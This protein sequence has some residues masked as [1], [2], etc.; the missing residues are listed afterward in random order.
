MGKLTDMIQKALR[1]DVAGVVAAAVETKA[2]KAD[3]KASKVSL[4]TAEQERVAELAYIVKS[5]RGGALTDADTKELSAQF[6]AV[7]V[8]GD[9]PALLPD[10]FTGTLLRDI[11]NELNVAKLF[12]M[13]QVAGGV[14]HDLIALGGVTAYLTS[15]A[16]DGTDSAESYLTFVKTT[17]KVMAVVRKSYEAVND[18]LIDLA[19]EIRF[20]LVR[21]IAEA[22]EDAVINGDLSVTHMDNGVAAASAK[23]VCNGIR[24]HALGKATVDFGGAA[25][26][27]DQ[28]FAKIVEMQ[29]AGG[30]YLSDVEVAKGNV[31]LVVDN[32]TYSK[33]RLFDSFKTLDKA[34]SLATLFGG[35][36]KSVFGIPVV[37]T[38]MIPSVDATGVVSATALD[39]VYGTAVMLNIKMFKLFANGNV[40]SEND[41][42][43]VNQTMLWTSGL[44]FGFAGIY[45][46]TESAPNTVSGTY[47]T[48]VI[49]LKIVK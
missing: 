32:Y 48:A 30:K 45:D 7:G 27:E 38:T 18:S 23:R 8:T 14:A 43:V 29:L 15:E 22:I 49:G 31:V 4:G 21:A 47:K 40:I 41:K 33:F 12:P 5:L 11:Q 24:K 20:E 28:M 17:K 10:G 13:G 16:N 3:F 2:P 39:N 1:E 9:I 37:S 25:L 44:R 6:K 35:E 26:T 19:A 46:S 36:I 42:N 34:G